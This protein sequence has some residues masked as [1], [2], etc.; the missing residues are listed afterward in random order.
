LNASG[1]LTTV[2]ARVALNTLRARTTLREQPLEMPLPDMIIDATD[3]SDPEHEA[4]LP[5]SVGLA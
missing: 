5:D 4:L 3:G 1:W 2:V